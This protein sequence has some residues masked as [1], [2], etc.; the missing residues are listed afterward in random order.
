MEKDLKYFKNLLFQ[1]QLPSH[2]FLFDLAEKCSVVLEQE[3]NDY[4]PAANSGEAGSLLDYRSSS[5]P[6]VVIP[7][8]HARPKFIYNI[9]KYPLTEEFLGTKTSYTILEA[10]ERKLINLVCVGDALHTEHSTI[11]R[12]FT[13]S[14]EFKFGVTTGNAMS[15]E[16]K[17]GL[18]T[19]S[20]LMEL[21]CLFPENFHFLK[22]NHE[23]IMNKS[24]DGD[25]GFRKYADEGKMV[26]TFITDY[27][28]DDVLYIMSCV[29][30]DLPLI[31][32]N[33]SCVI[34]H[35]EPRTGF[36]KEQLI[37]AR[38]DAFVVEGL[39]WTDNDAAESGSVE[40][41][42]KNLS[43][44]DDVENYVYLGGHRPVSDLY[45][46]R[47]NGKYI[48]FHNPAAQHIALVK[49]GKKFNPDCDLV[50]VDC[51]Y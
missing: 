32:I 30:Y 40:S 2:D 6:L 17:D 7:D 38:S 9:L 15:E 43:E 14:T 46:L 33:P 36:T 12:W 39:T 5:L 45:K 34:S 41:I 47:Q 50:D 3:I 26:R 18:N 21:K 37:N 51:E 16:M 20:A 35:A 10:L 8:I 44:L 24:G 48:Q 42:I 49:N 11:I 13:I 23:N 27:Y 31:F 19:V 25:Y 29:E 22:G 4:R 1:S 28:G